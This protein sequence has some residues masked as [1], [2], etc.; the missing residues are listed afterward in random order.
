MYAYLLKYF[1]KKLI[2]WDR[3]GKVKRFWSGVYL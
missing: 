3:K 1:F 2:K